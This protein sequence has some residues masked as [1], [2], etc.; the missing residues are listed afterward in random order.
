MR[1]R[2]RHA[3]FDAVYFPRFNTAASVRALNRYS[4]MLRLARLIASME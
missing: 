4:T 3:L 2:Y 1:E